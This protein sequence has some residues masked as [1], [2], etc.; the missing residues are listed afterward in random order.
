MV[1]VGA[2]RWS[3]LRRICFLLGAI[4]F[5]GSSDASSQL[6]VDSPAT[7]VAGFPVP[8][9][10]VLA[11]PGQVTP[12]NIFLPLIPF[13]VTLQGGGQQYEF[14][15]RRVIEFRPPLHSTSPPRPP[16]RT[17]LAP[18]T[19]GPGAT[20]EYVFDLSVMRCRA[21]GNSNQDIFGHEL[22]AGT[23]QVRVDGEGLSVTLENPTLTLTEPNPEER[24]FQRLLSDEFDLKGPATELEESIWVLF[25]RESNNILSQIDL[26]LFSP[27][28]LDQLQYH[29]V[30]ARLAS[31]PV[32]ISALQIL[33]E[34]TE[35]LL[36]AYETEML[37]L[38]HEIEV[39]RSDSAAASATESQILLRRNLGSG[40]VDHVQIKTGVIAKIRAIR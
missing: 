26:G 16:S 33:P 14:P 17:R 9:Q 5:L 25:L 13:T 35:T 7:A 38:R 40:N 34:D 21:C 31:E 39:A 10:L 3:Q 27:E 12:S 15:A 6:T 2:M 30:L 20:M 32:P 22:P 37:V 23:Y 36:P 19:V 11:G 24:R 28:S 8:V 4:L 29:L 1:R 18:V